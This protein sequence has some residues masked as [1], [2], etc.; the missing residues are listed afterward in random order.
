MAG[1]QDA[2]TVPWE[3]GQMS[4]THWD[5][6]FTG[7]LAGTSAVEAVMLGLDDGGPSI[8]VGIERIEGTLHGRAGSFVLLHSA[9]HHESGGLAEW[10]IAPGS[11]TGELTG[12]SGTGRI[13]PGHEFTLTYDLEP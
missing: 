3:G 4:R 10:V 6:T 1:S 8:Y 12:I 5:K 11:G 7:D 13:L 9:T 2:G